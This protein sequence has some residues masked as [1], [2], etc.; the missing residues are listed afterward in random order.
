VVVE[1]G[2]CVEVGG[3]MSIEM[4]PYP[5]SGPGAGTCLSGIRR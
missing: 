2:S 4:V 3:E 5:G 1:G